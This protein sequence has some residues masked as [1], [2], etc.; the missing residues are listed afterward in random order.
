[1]HIRVQLMQFM[2]IFNQY[3][4]MITVSAD[5]NLLTLGVGNT[6]MKWLKSLTFLKI[7]SDP[8]SGY[9]DPLS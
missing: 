4:F 7:N 9:C 6:T 2:H 1:M 8:P 3:A 5:L